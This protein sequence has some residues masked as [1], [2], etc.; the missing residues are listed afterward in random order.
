MV[1]RNYVFPKKERNKFLGGSIA[2]AVVFV[3]LEVVLIFDCFVL[4]KNNG[5]AILI[6]SAIIVCIIPDP[7]KHGKY[8]FT[9]YEFVQDSV[10]LFC[11]GK[12]I[13]EINRT[14]NVNASV[15][16]LLYV[17]RYNNT[18]EKFIVIWPK[19]SK[20][21][22]YSEISP[23]VAMRK[24]GAVVLPY[25]QEFLNGVELSL[26]INCIPEYP[27]YINKNTDDSSL[28]SAGK[29]LE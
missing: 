17:S 20:K 29:N 8:R 25:E 5:T 21:E 1:N 16:K 19:D 14:D 2:F 11:F 27:K 3:L 24:Y 23:Y 15:M 6:F 13:N 10:K 28:S 12:L 9:C 22:P 26:G 4:G 18:L 7:I